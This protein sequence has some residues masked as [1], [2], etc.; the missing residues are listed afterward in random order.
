MGAFL[1]Q[2]ELSSLVLSVF[3]GGVFYLGVLIILNWQQ[4]SSWRENGWRL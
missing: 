1:Q 4:F 2:A 3:L